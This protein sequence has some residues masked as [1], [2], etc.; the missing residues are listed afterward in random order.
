MTR[1]NY[2]FRT[3]ARAQF[4]EEYAHV[5]RET[6]QTDPQRQ[7]VHDNPRIAYPGFRFSGRR[8]RHGNTARI[9]RRRWRSSLSR[10]VSQ[11]QFARIRGRTYLRAPFSILPFLPSPSTLVTA[12]VLAHRVSRVNEKYERYQGRVSCLPN[13]SCPFAR[14]RARGIEAVGFM[15]AMGNQQGGLTKL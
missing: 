3:R 10:W 5:R 15:E 13:Y 9:R 1:N 7:N 11:N 6:R 8:Q 4:P 14:A 2:T 12:A